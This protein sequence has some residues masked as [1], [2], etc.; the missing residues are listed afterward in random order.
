MNISRRPMLLIVGALTINQLVR[1]PEGMLVDTE[2]L[3]QCGNSLI[4]QVSAVREETGFRSPSNSRSA[5]NELRRVSGLT[6]EQL[7][8][9]FQV[10]R[11]AVHNWASGE[12]L[13]RKNE[14]RL[15][16]A[17]ATL[18]F[19]DRGLSSLNRAV[20]TQ[21]LHDGRIPFQLL[22]EGAFEEVRQAL[23]PGRSRSISTP[24]SRPSV[25]PPIANVAE[26]VMDDEEATEVSPPLPRKS[27]IPLKPK[28]GLG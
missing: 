5:V 13:N 22:K 4:R 10:S 8:D 15:G 23:G 2:R 16:H 7:G 1:I 9:L 6:W 14:S 25:R 3:K 18:R 28:K 27:F 24:S 11:R 21:P 26:M 17:L 12:T 20:L 19:I